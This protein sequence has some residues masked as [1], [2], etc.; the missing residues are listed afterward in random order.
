M[1]PIEA[2]DTTTTDKDSQ[3]QQQPVFGV[4]KVLNETCEKERAKV[5]FLDQLTMV[6]EKQRRAKEKALRALQ[7][8]ANMLK[9]TKEG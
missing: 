7:E 3:Q 2:S 8:D 1:K 9:I 5:F 6:E 4:H